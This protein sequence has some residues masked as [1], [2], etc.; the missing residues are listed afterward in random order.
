MDSKIIKI[1]N[2]Q[3]CSVNNINMMRGQVLKLSSLR[4][5]LHANIRDAESAKSSASLMNN[6]LFGL[7]V[8]KATC[9]VVI[10]VVGEAF[11]NRIPQVA[12]ISSIYSAVQPSAELGGKMIAGSQVTGADIGTAAVAGL[13]HGVKSRLGLEGD[14]GSFADYTKAKADIM[15]NAAA[16]DEKALVDSL[17]NYGVVLTSW[18]FEAAGKQSVGKAIKITDELRK[19]GLAYNSAFNDWKKGDMDATFDSGIA[20]SRRQLSKI[21]AQISELEST[22][23]AC[24]AELQRFTSPSTRLLTGTQRGISIGPAR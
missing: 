14:M 23:I 22:L 18:T 12:A 4:A 19:A 13:H 8:T 7:Q 5:M 6:L 21:A 9:D 3:T 15:V 2:A 20:I 11:G 24:G 17:I 10:G 16:M 1:A